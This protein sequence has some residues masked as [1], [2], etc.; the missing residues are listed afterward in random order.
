MDPVL[1]Q[2]E[3]RVPGENLR[4]LVESS[5]RVHGGWRRVFILKCTRYSRDNLTLSMRGCAVFRFYFRIILRDTWTKNFHDYLTL[6]K[7]TE[8]VPVDSTAQQ[9][10][11]R[12]GISNVRVQ[13]ALE[14]TFFNWLWQ[15]Q[16]ITKIFC[17]RIS[18]DDSEIGRVKLA[19][20]L[21]T[22]N[23]RNFNQITA[24]SRNSTQI[25]VVGD[26]C[27]T[28]V[29]PAPPEFGLDYK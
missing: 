16:I 27:T 17:S 21:L 2:E 5:Y 11:R 24:R 13:I 7:S 18:E 26:T 15:C 25:T 1:L 14:P 10:K 20:T 22:Y 23:K 8:K 9:V 12:T 4:C 29:P 6:P 28:T 3:T 19:N